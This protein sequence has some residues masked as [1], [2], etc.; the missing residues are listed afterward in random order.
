[1]R[2]GIIGCGTI[3]QF[4][5][6]K[7]NQEKVLQG[8]KITAILDEREK[9]V[10]KLQDFSTRYAVDS[11]Q[12]LDQFLQ[13]SIDIVIES[14]NIEFVEKYATRIV[15]EKDLLMISIG[16]LS[17]LSFHDKLASTVQE[18]GRM[19]YLPTGAIGG[20]DLVKAA[21]VIGGL[22][23]VTLISRKPLHALSDELLTE[24][25]ILFK[26]SA[27]EA[28]EKFPKN[29]NVAI[30]LSYAGIGIEKT[31][32]QIIADPT[33]DKNIHSIQIEGDFGRAEVKIENNPSPTNPKTSFLTALSILSTLE[34]LETQI[35]IG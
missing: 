6:E 30:A 3:G 28:I 5:L 10:E 13:S 29:A 17:N 12:D 20:L 25:T 1:M 24:E 22:K 8:Y 32:V 9:S 31:L 4:L 34:S 11:Y 14:A 16:A 19:V 18:S 26:G 2:I 33:I 27:K 23:T 35:H 7:V 21:N 15:K